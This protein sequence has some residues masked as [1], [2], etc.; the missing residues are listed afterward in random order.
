MRATSEPATSEASRRALGGLDLLRVVAVALVTLQH[1]FTLTGHDAWTEFRFVEIGQV[2]V[3]I[4]LGNSA[5]LAAGSQRPP[6]PWLK[7]R[8]RRIYPA[9]W[10]AILF[11]FALVWLTGYKR[12]TLAQFVSQMFGL[13]LFTHRREL[14]N[15]PTWFIS[16]LLVCY[17]AMF[18]GRVVGRP[19]LLSVGVVVGLAIWGVL[20]GAPWPWFHLLTFFLATAVAIFFP[21][22]NRP[23]AFALAGIVACLVVPWFNALIYT[24]GTLL[25]IGAALQISSVPRLVTVVAEYSYE[26]YLLHGVFLIGSLK[27]FPTHPVFAVLLGI[28]AAAVAAVVLRWFVDRGM[29]WLT[30]SDRR[31]ATK[32]E[33]MPASVREAANASA[34]GGVAD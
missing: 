7:Q 1:A 32:I 18:V 3:A 29:S 9:Y 8:L 5:I 22:E 21:M 11:S 25:L 27:F 23:R 26:Y 24:A 34:D 13:G 6:V 31:G 20:G 33:A 19:L 14:V 12:F 30:S 17:F 28:A 4:F 10:I 15:V 2:G 16:I